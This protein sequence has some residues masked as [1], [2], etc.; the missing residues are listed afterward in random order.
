VTSQRLR[1]SA[2]AAGA[3]ALGALAGCGSSS[4][5]DKTTGGGAAAKTT[6]A[7]A[8][9]SG[10]ISIVGAWTGPEQKSFQAVI[11][12]FH[13]KW[14]K[15]TVKYQPAGDNEPTVLGTAV[16]GGHPPDMA[17]IAQPGLIKQFQE[18]GA[19]KPIDWLK[20]TLDANYPT[21]FEKLGT[22]DSH[23]YDFVFKGANKSTVWYNVAAFKSAGVE[24]PK[25]WADF[26]KD[27]STIKA[28]GTPAYSLGGADGWT[29][30]DL[31]E[32]I[33]LR[34]AGPD[35]YDALTNH[36]IKWTDPTVKTTLATM[37]KLFGDTSNIAGGKSGALQTDFPTSVS[38]VFTNPAKAAM[39]IEGDFV[40]G[41]VAGKSKLKA[42]T[43]YNAF[44]FPAI[45]GAANDVVGGGDSIAVFNDTPAVEAFA[46]F[47]ASPEGATVWAQRGGFSTPNKMVP[48]SVYPDDVTRTVAQPLST[49]ETFRFDMSDQEPAAFGGTPGQGEWKIL[50]DF[51]GNPSDVDG[52][53]SKLEA[54]A[55]KAFA[56]SS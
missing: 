34:Q 46:K 35:K 13:A 43:G 14:P 20:P 22:I 39:V 33:Y 41:V 42:L 19:V 29:L 23:L 28:S 18:K 10:S 15:V 48:A 2:L 37:A 47:L 44:P 31:F 54:A 49:A 30:T 51:L 4:H 45:N 6:N 56:K 53:A 21:D 26:V 16:A 11:D 38:H 7:A 36:T 12:A 25:T 55:A 8:S 27:A 5:K 1:L 9:V 52:T 3:V 32:N 40:P 50:Q 17:A 24:A